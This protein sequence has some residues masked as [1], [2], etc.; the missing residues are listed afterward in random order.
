MHPTTPLLFPR[1]CKEGCKINGYEIPLKTKVIINA[2][3]IGRDPYYWTKAKRFHLKQFLNSP[4][5]YKGNN[6]ECIPFGAG[7]RICHGIL[8]AIPN[9]EL[10]LANMLNHFDLELPC[11]IKQDDLDMTK[12]FGLT[13]KRKQDLCLIL[14][15]HNPL[16]VE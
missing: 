9:I 3:A 16:Y 12:S 5:D 13:V 14:I 11:G 15:P 4:I 2:W 1:E 8:F 6:F 10:P 7:K